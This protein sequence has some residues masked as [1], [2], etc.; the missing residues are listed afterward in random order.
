M[1]KF[2]FDMLAGPGEL[3]DAFAFAAL[4]NGGTFACHHAGISMDGFGRAYA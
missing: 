1:G 4:A 3:P 2:N